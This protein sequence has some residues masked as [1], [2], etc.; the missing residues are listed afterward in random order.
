LG[1]LA[2]SGLTSRVDAQTAAMADA[3]PELVVE[4]ARTVTPEEIRAHLGTAASGAPDARAIDEAI[5]KLMETGL[6]ADV[7]IEPRGGKPHVTVVENPVMAA[8]TFEG[9]SAIEKKQLEEATKL[10]ARSRY[11]Q[12]RANA[13]AHS[14]K[15]LYVRAGRLLTTVEPR[16]TKLKDE[17]INLT[18]A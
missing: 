5:T 17:R 14:I 9:N 10:K 7:H 6:F 12:A 11:S 15:D 1:A 2:A 8:V 18:F 13:D 3:V 16:V 4:G